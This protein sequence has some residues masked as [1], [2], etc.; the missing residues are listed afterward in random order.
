MA[1][2]KRVLLFGIMGGLVLSAF[3]DPAFAQDAAAS[4]IKNKLQGLA[5][6]ALLIGVVWMGYLMMVGKLDKYQ[7]LLFFFGF[8]IVVGGGFIAASV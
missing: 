1:N 2:S 7:A 6:P 4:D 5:M 8:L 3:A